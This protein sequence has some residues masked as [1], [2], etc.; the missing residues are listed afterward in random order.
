[1]EETTN[2]DEQL[3]RSLQF[4][5]SMAISE[6]EDGN[7][8]QPL[9]LILETAA[10]AAASGFTPA[11]RLAT[12]TPATATVHSNTPL[13]NAEELRKVKAV[14]KE[15]SKVKKSATKQANAN[16]VAALRANP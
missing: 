8:E 1:M 15:K 4:E 7:N 11:R 9:N 16:A 10:D 5:E 12:R 6:T 14:A 13:I 2:F 3:A